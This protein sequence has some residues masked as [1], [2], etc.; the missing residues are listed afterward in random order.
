MVRLVIRQG[1]VVVTVG[2][3]LGLIGTLGLSRV[4]TSFLFG[5]TPTDPT[6]LI[7][8]VIALGTVAVAA[9]YVPSRRAAMVDPMTT[10]RRG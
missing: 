6:T 3:A 7:L 1:L 10:L 2:L 8:V 9:C 4:R 5:V